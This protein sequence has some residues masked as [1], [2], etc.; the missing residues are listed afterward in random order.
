M[1]PC[2]SIGPRTLLSDCNHSATATIWRS[3]ILSEVQLPT[4]TIPFLVWSGP[5]PMTSHHLWGAS[6]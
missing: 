1:I 5:V 2:H 4:T 3:A 6:G